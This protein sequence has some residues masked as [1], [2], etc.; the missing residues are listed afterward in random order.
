MVNIICVLFA[1]AAI[2]G[3]ALSLANASLASA[4]DASRSWDL[5][6]GRIGDRLRS[7][8]ALVT[9]DIGGSGAD[10]DTSVRNS[11][12]TPQAEFTSW[13]VWIKYYDNPNNQDLRIVRLTHTTSTTPAHGHWTV[14]GI[15]MDASAATSEVYEPNVLNPGE[16]MVLRLN[17]TPAISTSTD[18]LISVATEHGATLAVPFSR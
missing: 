5:M 4:G 10:I 8:L 14:E 3:V 17:I 13:D 11:G 1:I 2:T 12:Q 9:A 18:N 7:E 15:Y 6:V 16:E